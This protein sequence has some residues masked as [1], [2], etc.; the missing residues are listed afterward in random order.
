MASARQNESCQARSAQ[1]WMRA[2]TATNKVKERNVPASLGVLR[3]H[4][5][6]IAHAPAR[7]SCTAWSSVMANT[8][9]TASLKIHPTLR[10]KCKTHNPYLHTCS[11]LLHGLVRC[12]AGA[13]GPGAVLPVALHTFSARS[14]ERV[15]RCLVSSWAPQRRKTNA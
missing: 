10:V 8:L 7:S 13:H 5:L 12:D 6:I 14:E 3:T 2:L 9:K 4:T 15:S 1:L 11:Q